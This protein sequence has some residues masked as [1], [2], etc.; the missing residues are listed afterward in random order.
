MALRCSLCSSRYADTL[1]WQAVDLGATVRRESER[2]RGATRDYSHTR[3]FP[4]FVCSI[5]DQKLFSPAKNACPFLGGAEYF[6]HRS[7]SDA[8]A[9]L[10]SDFLHRSRTREPCC[11]PYASAKNQRGEPDDR[12]NAREVTVIRV[13]H[14]RSTSRIVQK[15]SLHARPRVSHL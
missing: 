3:V 15:Y 13:T 12:D 10:W 8:G 9:R 6:W 11:P 4:Y 7:V 2:L 5:V 1:V 14:L